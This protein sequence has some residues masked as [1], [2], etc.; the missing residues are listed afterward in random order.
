MRVVLRTCLLL[1]LANLA[2]PAS[3]G[4]AYT[5]FCRSLGLGWGPGYH[6][7]NGCP[8]GNCQ[9]APHQGH[10]HAV[11]GAPVWRDVPAPESISPFDPLQSKPAPATKPHTSSRRPTD[12]QLPSQRMSQQP[13]FWYK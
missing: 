13:V 11:Y 8:S 6:A 9:P 4:Q 2:A 7:Y 3:A 5:S 1:A 12:P 10:P